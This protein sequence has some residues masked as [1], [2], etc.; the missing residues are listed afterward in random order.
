MNTNRNL[1][2]T[3]VKKG[4][5]F[6]TDIETKTVKLSASGGITLKYLTFSNLS[7]TD[8]YY[9]RWSAGDRCNI[10]DYVHAA[11]TISQ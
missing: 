5:L 2:I 10:E 9:I 6:D 8:K 7:T 3:L 1:D 4:T 11:G